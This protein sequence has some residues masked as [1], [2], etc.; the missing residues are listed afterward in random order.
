VHAAVRAPARPGARAGARLAFRVLT[1]VLHLLQPLARLR[2]RLE[3]GLTPWRCHPGQLASL[4]RHVVS[5][6]SEHWRSTEDRL[7]SLES[8]VRAAGLPVRR[9]GDFDAWDLEVRGGALGSVRLLMA[10]EEHGAG[11]QFVRVRVWPRGSRVGL[12]IA[13]AAAAMAGAALAGGHW[14]PAGLM[15]GAALLTGLRVARACAA[16]A[17]AALHALQDKDEAEKHVL[18][19]AA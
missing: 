10:I 14:A 3:A 4:G 15:G 8:A 6:W 18:N 9:G 13:G 12:A 5:I 7:A 17:A 1:A 2:G 16:A 11:R 19:Q